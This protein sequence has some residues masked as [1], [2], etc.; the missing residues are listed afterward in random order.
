[1]KTKLLFR[2]LGGFVCAFFLS[3]I[4]GKTIGQSPVNQA[5]LT[6]I[7]EGNQVFIQEK[8]AKLKDTARRNQQVRTGMA[9]A[10]LT[11]DNKAIARL[12]KNTRFTVGECGVQLQQ[13][14]AL[15]SGT[16]ACTRGVTAAVRG[17]TYL[18]TVND[19]GTE[20]YEVLEGAVDFS[21]TS[22][23]DPHKWSMDGGD[24]CILEP[25]RKGVIREK[26]SRG[27]YTRRLRGWAFR[28]FETDE[29]RFDRLKSTYAKLFPNT[30]FPLRRTLNA[31]RGNFILSIK[32]NR[33]LVKEVIAR[34]SWQR[35]RNDVYLP[36]RFVGDF[37]FPINQK[38]QFVS[39]IE[40]F[41]RISV[42][43]FDR[44]NRF[45]G[46]TE[47]EGLD[48]NAAVTVIL[49]DD[50]QFYGKVRTVL[51]EDSDRN[52]V[53]DGDAL[54]YDFI[55]LVK[56]PTQPL[57]EKIEVI[58]P[59]RLEDINRSVLVAE[60]IPAIGDTPEFPDGFYEPLF[61]PLNRS[62]FPFRPGL[63]APLLTVPAKVYPLVPVKPDGSSVFQVPREILKYRS[64][65]LLS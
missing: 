46:Y 34:I 64:R 43:L 51:G 39:G 4:A 23:E 52:G 12:S 27:E 57:R 24:R 15:I 29:K 50:P 65:R 37:V 62:T 19:N 8:Q 40:P 44:D 63:E 20:E 13:G 7:L 36:E 21:K 35:R 18:L 42:R 33:P 38:A 28:G 3:L 14:T 1:M 55:S 49:P 58:F 17:T 6:A 60:P 61:S 9:R 16:S 25:D 53:I 2:L 11:F 47:F 54:T 31:N 59:Q 41:H 26:L 22:Q 56:N 48:D 30:R 5:T 32:Q 10:E 45:L